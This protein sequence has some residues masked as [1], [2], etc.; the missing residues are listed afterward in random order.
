MILLSL[1]LNPHNVLK[2]ISVVQDTFA[3][4]DLGELH[5]FLGK[6]FTCHRVNT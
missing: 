3:L 6:E 2:V 4:K 5:Y 1:D